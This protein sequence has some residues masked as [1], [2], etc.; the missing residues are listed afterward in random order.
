MVFLGWLAINLSGLIPIAVFI[1]LS[2][3]WWV[4]RF[5]FWGEVDVEAVS[6]SL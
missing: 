4:N 2:T 1:R 6:L 5:L 3:I